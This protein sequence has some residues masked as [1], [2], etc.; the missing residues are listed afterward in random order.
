MKIDVRRVRVIFDIL[1]LT[2]IL[3][4]LKTVARAAQLADRAWGPAEVVKKQMVS[5]GDAR[6]GAA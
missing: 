4:L 1:K 6:S 5:S 2:N 3:D